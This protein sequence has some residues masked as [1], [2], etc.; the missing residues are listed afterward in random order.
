MAGVAE[1]CGRLMLVDFCGLVYAEPDFPAL[2][3][4]QAQRGR[5]SC[6]GEP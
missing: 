1:E 3:H 6:P 5:A 4:I 2:S